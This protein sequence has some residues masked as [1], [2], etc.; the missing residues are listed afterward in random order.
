MEGE[1]LH[2]H[3][4]A[5][6]G[7]ELQ[8]TELQIAQHINRKKRCG[9][10]RSALHGGQKQGKIPGV[11]VAQQPQTDPLWRLRTR[12]IRFT[13]L[14]HA[15]QVIDRNTAGDGRD[16][17]YRQ[18][19]EHRPAGGVELVQYHAGGDQRHECRHCR[20][21]RAAPE[22]AS[23]LAFR[24]QIAHQAD[25]QRRRQIG[26]GVIDGDAHHQD[27]NGPV[28]IDQRQDHQG[29]QNEGL[30]SCPSQYHRKAAQQL[31]PPS[32]TA[33]SC[34]SEPSSGGSVARRPT[35][36]AVALG[37]SANAEK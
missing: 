13:G 21:T 37:N 3:R 20:Q 28:A 11:R 7:H 9:H 5:G 8:I 32:H 10:R 25:P 17:E 4:H 6:I 12:R 18:E 26:A 19:T 29:Q 14:V 35:C 30:Q 33:S 24:H 1:K 2:Q 34:A 22:E 31:R 15:G 16:D 36:G 23:P 27:E